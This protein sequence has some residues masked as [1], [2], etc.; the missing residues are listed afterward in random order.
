MSRKKKPS[1][2]GTFDGVHCY[3]YIKEDSNDLSERK[4]CAEQRMADR[5]KEVKEK[6]NC[7]EMQPVRG[8]IVI[9]KGEMGRQLLSFFMQSNWMHTH[10]Q[11]FSCLLFFFCAVTIGIGRSTASIHACSTS[12]PYGIQSLFPHRTILPSFKAL[13]FTTCFS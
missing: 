12:L 6:A 3:R 7:Q 8:L 5:F 9:T 11:S 13:N 2:C 4:V 10:T 1:L